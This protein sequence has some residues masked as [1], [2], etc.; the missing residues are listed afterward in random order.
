MRT[1]VTNN[2]ERLHICPVSTKELR[3]ARA[4][5]TAKDLVGEDRMVILIP[6]VNFV[7]VEDLAQC[8]ESPTFEAK[9]KTKIPKH[10]AKECVSER[11]GHPMLVQ[12]KTVPDDRPLSTLTV[13]EALAI[14]EDV[15]LVNE[16]AN[17]P[18][19]LKA[20]LRVEDR[21]EVRRAITERIEL[22]ESPPDEET[23]NETWGRIGGFGGAE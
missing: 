7:S 16:E 6:G 14:V 18:Y 17:F 1:I 19:S 9:F 5:G 8:R 4:N 15:T 10:K 13:D 11:V 22:L 2:E 3:T 12:G 21:P 23:Q 20:L